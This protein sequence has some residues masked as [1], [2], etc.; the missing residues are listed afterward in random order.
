MTKK[1]AL[2]TGIAS[3]TIAGSTGALV[4]GLSQKTANTKIAARE[5]RQTILFSWPKEAKIKV[6]ESL[7]IKI[8]ANTFSQ[9]TN[10][11]E[12]ALKF[13][14]LKLEFLRTDP[15]NP[16]LNSKEINERGEVLMTLEKRIKGEDELAKLIFLGKSEGNCEI[17]FSENSNLPEVGGGGN[18]IKTKI[19]S[20]VAIEK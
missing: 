17:F 19:G 10:G 8:N 16:S 4:Y 7:L 14:P 1:L 9:E 6:G 20:E 15:E 13:D 12:I 2:L 5:E 11:G 18:T 3:L